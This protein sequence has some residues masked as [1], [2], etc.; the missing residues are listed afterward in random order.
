[1]ANGTVVTR[2]GLQLITK[3]VASETAL[4]FTRV[5]IGT[6]KVPGGYDPG[7]M[8][9]LNEYKM[10]GSIASHS[11]S[12]D[13]AS[14]V[15]QISSIGVE[16]GFTI[17]EAGLFATDP[18][19]GEILYAYLD[20]SADPQYMYPENNAIS[21]FIEMTLVVKIGEVQSVT[22]VINPG[23][24][25][26]KEKFDEIAYPTL[27]KLDE[28]KNEQDYILD[29]GED[30]RWLLARYEYVKQHYAKSIDLMDE[31]RTSVHQN[32][33][34]NGFGEGVTGD[35]VTVMGTIL[36][37]KHDT[38]IN[39][40]KKYGLLKSMITQANVDSLDKIPSAYLLYQLNK[41]LLD[42]YED[43]LTKYNELNS[44]LKNTVYGEGW[45]SS[46]SVSVPRSGST[47]L[48][49]ASGRNDPGMYL[50][51]GVGQTA[52]V[53]PIFEPAKTGEL[54]TYSISGQ[55]VTFS[56]PE[57][58]GYNYGVVLFDKKL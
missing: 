8:T 28:S 34:I 27:P 48:V 38:D 45:Q 12:G 6:G 16:T 49:V 15:M 14:V 23:S 22:A 18:D 35:L 42:K 40:L 4:T 13:E 39:Y 29:G 9:G 33:I 31:K 51:Y 32:D 43:L 19:E 50:I 44:N 2:K 54:I 26:T 58:R 46:Y 7:S 56:S 30:I 17:T 25:V 53:M 1:M 10:D 11:A 37:Q 24:L 55:Q 20:M 52:N 41:D 5:A 47:A 3:L 21:K 36:G 57:N